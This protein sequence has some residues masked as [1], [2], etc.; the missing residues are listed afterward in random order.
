MRTLDD[1]DRVKL[2]EAQPADEAEY[3]VMRQSMRGTL[4]QRMLV[5]EQSAGIR[6]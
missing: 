1:I 5:E 3:L 2:D 6:I 4:A